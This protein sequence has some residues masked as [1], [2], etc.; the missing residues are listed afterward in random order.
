VDKGEE[1]EGGRIKVDTG[2]D[3]PHT[4]PL[5]FYPSNEEEM[6]LLC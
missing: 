2:A 6:L 3:K 4:Y 1:E 5:H